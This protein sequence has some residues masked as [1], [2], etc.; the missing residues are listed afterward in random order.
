MG[1]W[2]SS[3][4]STHIDR[5]GHCDE[6]KN[7]F[8]FSN[9]VLVMD[10]DTTKNIF[11]HFYGMNANYEGYMSKF[12]CK[13]PFYYSV[14]EIAYEETK[15]KIYKEI[16]FEHVLSDFSNFN[17]K[18]KDLSMR[19]LARINDFDYTSLLKTT[20]YTEKDT[21]L[22]LELPFFKLLMYMVAIGMK[23][24]DIL[25]DLGTSYKNDTENY[26]AMIAPLYILLDHRLFYNYESLNSQY[27]RINYVNKNNI[28]ED[29]KINSISYSVNIDFQKIKAL[30]NENIKVKGVI[31]KLRD[32]L[33]L[34]SLLIETQ[35]Q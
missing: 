20:T 32:S 25:M 5:T 19:D 21:S 6:N 31:D 33:I 24:E 34:S 27:I 4:I 28:I 29:I 11:E 3:G 1:E 14:K 16:G 18:L 13:K 15:N 35:Q 2:V 8:G 9:I 30:Q 22:S 26:I 17:K 10:Y 7:K 23:Y 12:F